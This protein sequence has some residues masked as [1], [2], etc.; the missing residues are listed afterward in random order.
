MTN[1][2]NKLD[3]YSKLNLSVAELVDG[4]QT[5]LQYIKCMEIDVDNTSMTLETF[6]EDLLGHIQDNAYYD[7]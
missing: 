4:V 6:V 1:K 2:I 3:K 7:Y 5:W